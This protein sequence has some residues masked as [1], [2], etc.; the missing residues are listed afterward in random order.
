MSKGVLTADPNTIKAR[1]EM[2][3]SELKVGL[4]RFRRLVN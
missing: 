4:Q 2:L 3:A 1:V